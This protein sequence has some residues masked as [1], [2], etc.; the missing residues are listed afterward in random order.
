MSSENYRVRRATLDDL[1]TLKPMWEAMRFPSADLERRMTEFQVVE[2]SAG[3]VLGAVGFQIAGRH[4]HIYSE[5]YS[6]FGVADSVRPLIW[7]R[8]QALSTNHGLVRLWTQEPAPFWR[9]H[10]LLPATP[11]ALKS[12]PESWTGPG[13]W[14]TLPLKDENSIVSLE[15]ELAM[16]MQAEKQ[17]SARTLSQ[18][19]TL[20]TIATVI[21][22]IFAVIVIGG[23]LY[24]ASKN[25]SIFGRRR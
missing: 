24:I 5:A 18:A 1:P 21:A 8:I 2:S 13:E 12:L 14:L 15:K 10:G 20:K 22:V 9:Q 11:E 25:P 17:R 4:A 19:R 3:K 7:N 23:T 6:D 16:Y